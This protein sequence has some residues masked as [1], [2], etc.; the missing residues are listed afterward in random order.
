MALTDVNKRM[1]G[2]FARLPGWLNVLSFSR[3]RFPLPPSSPPLSHI[4]ILDHTCT[5]CSQVYGIS[6][7]DSFLFLFHIS[8]F[9]IYMLFS[10]GCW[11]WSCFIHFLYSCF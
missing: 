3:I 1:L 4:S 11:R 6:G 9:F 10:F 7:S 8:Y 2:K 5:A